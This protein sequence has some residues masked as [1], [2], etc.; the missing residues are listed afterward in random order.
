MHGNDPV[1]WQVW[2]EDTVQLAKKLNRPLLISSGYFSC[3]WCHVMQRESYQDPLLAKLLNTYFIPVKIDRELEPALDAY[4]IEFVQLTRGRAGWPLNVFLTPEGYPVLGMTYLPRERFY[5]VLQQLQERWQSEPDEL[6]RIAGNALA[7]WRSMR[8]PV[9]R[10]EQ[11][12]AAIAPK[13]IAETGRLIDELSGGFGEQNKFPMVPQLR[14]LL[15][16]RGNI[17]EHKW[18]DEFLRLT[19]DKMESQGMHDLVGGGFFRYVVDP[20]WQT[21]HYEKMLYDNAQLV[22]LYL[23]GATDFKEQRYRDAAFETLDFML[24]EMWRDNYFISSF[25]A[26]DEQGREGAYY[27]WSDA[28]LEK[29]LSENEHEL[30]QVAWFDGGI[31]RSA[32]GKLPRWQ[33]TEAELSK[34]TGQPASDLRRSLAV[35]REK[36]L[37]ARATRSLPADGKGLAAWNGLALSAL[38]DAVE[39]DGGDVYRRHGD[40]LA[41]YLATKLWD[42]E[43]LVRA[44]DA[45][46]VLADGSLQDYALVAKGLKDWSRISG[47]MVYAQLASRMV[48]IAWQRFYRNDLWLQ[49]DEPLIPMLD[50]KLALDDNPLPSATALVVGLSLTTNSLKKDKKVHDASIAHL[51]QVRARLPDSIFWYASYVEWLDRE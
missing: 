42:G 20:D 46:K 40:K 15:N 10:P 51:G 21:P 44:L 33:M 50:G 34:R 47:D 45:G 23:R 41:N 29:L 17:P 6:Q 30:V 31:A 24:R 22:S 14:A 36:M 35:I 48:H 38:A 7:E 28:E 11:P 39:A 18:L 9:V 25:S 3:H 13:F 8:K 26:V 1:H 12:R 2:G 37:K 5:S 16:V 32:W 49:T 27:L 43:R 19:L 4:L